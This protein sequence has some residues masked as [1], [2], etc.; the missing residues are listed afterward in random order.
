TVIH[1]LGDARLVEDGNRPSLEKAARAILGKLAPELLVVQVI[2]LDTA[3][4]IGARQV[5][6]GAVVDMLALAGAVVL[7]KQA[8]DLV[9]VKILAA[10]AGVARGEELAD[11]VVGV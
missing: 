10:A 4:S 6:N 7:R 3:G 11:G 8:A 5:P 9:I 1:A 2:D